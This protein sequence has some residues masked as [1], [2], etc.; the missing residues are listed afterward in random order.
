MN[1]FLLTNYYPVPENPMNDV[2]VTKRLEKI[3]RHNINFN[4]FG[5][6]HDEN[7]LL[8]VLRT[9][10]NKPKTGSLEGVNFIETS[11]VRYNY[12]HIPFGLFQALSTRINP[13]RLTTVYAE[14]LFQIVE[15]KNYDLIHAH[16]IYPEGYVACLTKNK[17]NL[18]CV[19]TAHGSD[20][21]TLPYAQPK[22]KSAILKTLESADKVIFVSNALLRKSM[23]LGY[24]GENAIVIPNGVDLSLFSIM[25]KNRIRKHNGIYEDDMHYVGFVGNLVQVKRVDKLPE[26]FLKIKR[27]IPN[28]KFL[29]IGDGSLRDSIREKFIANG[30]DVVFTGRVKPEMV[31]SWMNCMDCLVLPSRN[32]GWGNV[33]LEAQACGVPVVG[34]NAGGIPEAVGEGGLIVEEGDDFE[35]RFAEAVCTVLRNPPSPEKLRKRAQE[36]DWEKTVQKEVEVY[37]SLLR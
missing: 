2:F 11:G 17:Y 9:L 10:L 34:S 30:L 25:D 29:I 16:C 37:Q 15:I 22:L 36:Y 27:E 21:H 24:S 7:V 20:I 4:A 23:E 12:I 1:I 31:S 13:L 14:Y 35:E 5:I 32:E 8:K 18:P 28:V 6:V 33:V 19:L 3:Y 26:I